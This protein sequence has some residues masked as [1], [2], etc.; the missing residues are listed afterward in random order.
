M[1]KMDSSVGEWELYF[2]EKSSSPPDK[3][4]GERP[5]AH[6]P[7]CL[8][9]LEQFG[10]KLKFKNNAY[11]I[12]LFYCPTTSGVPFLIVIIQIQ[13]QLLIFQII[14]SSRRLKRKT[15]EILRYFIDQFTSK[16]ITEPTRQRAIYYTTTIHKDMSYIDA[17]I[18]NIPN[19]ISGHKATSIIISFQYETQGTF[20]Y[21]VCYA[22]KRNFLYS[23]KIFLVLIGPV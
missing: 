8:F 7:S 16:Y 21:V 12:S 17:G 19:S 1:P 5:R 2:V 3:D 18:H 6:G 22:E 14:D 9:C 4:S 13:R 10:L 23:K 20:T 11:L 15:I